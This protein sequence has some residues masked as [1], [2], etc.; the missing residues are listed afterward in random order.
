MEKER[1]REGERGGGDRKLAR[2]FCLDFPEEEP[3]IGNPERLMGIWRW[4]RCKVLR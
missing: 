1:E 4:K 2:G 3:F